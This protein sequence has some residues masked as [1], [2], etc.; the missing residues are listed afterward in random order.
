MFLYKLFLWIY[1]ILAKIISPFNEKAKWWS[2]G[3]K[4]VWDEIVNSKKYI[5]KPI[6]WVHCASYGEFEQGLPII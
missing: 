5:T 2:L 4:Q 1:P 6:V 3:Q